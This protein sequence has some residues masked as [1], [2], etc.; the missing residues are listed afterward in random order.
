MLAWS[1][2]YFYAVV[3]TVASLVFFYAPPS[4]AFL[5]TQLEKRQG[6]ANAKLKH[7]I[8][9]DSLTGKDPILGISKDPEE[10][11]HEAVVEL[12]A[13]MEMRRRMGLPIPK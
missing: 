2:V 4:K 12:R 5:K 8:S 6:R 11:V 1:R 9:T 7:S 13:E 3:W 10:D